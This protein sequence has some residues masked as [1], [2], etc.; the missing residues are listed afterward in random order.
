MRCGIL[1]FSFAYN[2]GALLQALSL[3]RFLEKKGKETDVVSF[4]PKHILR[5]YSLNPFVGKWSIKSIVYNFLRMPFRIRQYKRFDTFIEEL[6]GGK[7]IF[8][9]EETLFNAEKK[10][11]A[12]VVGS[13][14]VWNDSITGESEVYYLPN[15]SKGVLKISYAASFGK[16]KLSEFQKQMCAKH[17]SSFSSLS[18]REEDGLEDLLKLSGKNVK[19]VLDPVFLTDKQEWTQLSSNSKLTNED[20]AEKYILF[21]S[22]SFDLKLVELANEI[23]EKLKL[24]IISI[25]PTAKKTHVKGKQLFNV[26]PYEFLSLMKNA[27]V[28]CTDSFHATAFSV[29]FNKKFLHIARQE[30]ESRV[31]SLLRRLNAYS[32]Q[33]K[34]CGLGNIIDFANVDKKLIDELIGE[35]KAY[36]LDAFLRKN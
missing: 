22:L 20:L 28:V 35:S 15:P 5:G 7:K 11:D 34:E 4:A 24:R 17:L 3:K 29:I 23:S 21:Y 18:L 19:I 27:E 31:E 26:G 6:H 9:D 1:T 36:L 25:H 14:Q 2:Y 30:R 16:K 8:S 33:Y 10:Y 12:L 32:N 13:D